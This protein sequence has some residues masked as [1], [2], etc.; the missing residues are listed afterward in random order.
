M[1][2]SLWSINTMSAASPNVSDNLVVSS[3]PPKP[4]PNT[5]TRMA[6]HYATRRLETTG[7]VRRRRLIAALL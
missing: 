1:N 2:P 6:E 7:T 3:N 5:T 4:A